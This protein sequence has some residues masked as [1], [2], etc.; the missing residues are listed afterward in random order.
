MGELSALLIGVGPMGNIESSR[1][2]S[3]SDSSPAGMG[4]L[5]IFFFFFFFFKRGVYVKVISTKTS[6]WLAE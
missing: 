3:Q 6:F 5:H 4:G 1:T 2:N